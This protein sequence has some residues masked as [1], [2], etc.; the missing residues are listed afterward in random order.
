MTG[1]DITVRRELNDLRG[2]E[3]P[4]YHGYI[5]TQIPY[6][7]PFYCA[8]LASKCERIT[9]SLLYSRQLEQILGI[10]CISDL[11]TLQ[12]EITE[13]KGIRRVRARVF[14]GLSPARVSPETR[15]VEQAAQHNEALA[16]S[17]LLPR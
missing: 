12:T 9:S 3:A 7:I 4:F 16:A 14:F 17:E 6:S 5:R 11:K 13:R 10:F 2:S 1:R 8:S 15:L